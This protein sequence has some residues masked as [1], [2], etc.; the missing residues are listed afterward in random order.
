VGKQPNGRPSN[1]VAFKDAVL[2]SMPEVKSM[3]AVRGVLQ[4]S[5]FDAVTC[6]HSMMV[7]KEGKVPPTAVLCTMW[8]TYQGKLIGQLQ[9]G[10]GGL[11]H[12]QGPSKAILTCNP[13]TDNVPQ[14]VT[15]MLYLSNLSWPSVKDQVGDVICEI[16]L[17]C[18]GL[19][20]LELVMPSS[21]KIQSIEE[22][23]RFPGLFQPRILERLKSMPVKRQNTR[24]ENLQV[25]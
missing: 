15:K 13:K 9:R 6:E 7:R 25:V 14:V 4:Q 3:L 20:N 17:V 21:E 12:Q 1:K 10:C 5:V 16:K 8:D 24:K 18:D 2:A 11:K 22:V 23:F 19:R